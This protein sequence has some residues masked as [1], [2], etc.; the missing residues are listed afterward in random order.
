MQLERVFLKLVCTGICNTWE[1]TCVPNL[2][3]FTFAFQIYH[4]AFTHALD[5]TSINHPQNLAIA[6]SACHMSLNVAAKE[7]NNTLNAFS[8]FCWIH[9]C[10]LSRS[11]NQLC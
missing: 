4:F 10:N 5:Q 8:P 11:L 2:F 6:E 1:A 3:V 7:L 9:F